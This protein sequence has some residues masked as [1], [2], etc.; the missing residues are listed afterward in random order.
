MT[1][2]WS[3]SAPWNSSSASIARVFIDSSLRWTDLNRRRPASERKPDAEVELHRVLALFRVGIP[4]QVRDDGAGRRDEAQPAPHRV[5]H[6]GQIDAG[7]VEPDASL[8]AEDRALQISVDREAHLRL[9]RKGHFAARRIAVDLRP[10]ALE[11]E[12]ADAVGAAGEFAKGDGDLLGAPD[13]GDDA[14]LERGRE[15]D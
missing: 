9:E 12:A 11:L 2:V 4:A 6:L 15:H 10:E 3:A 7:P 8:V 5:A 14:A 1:S 13:R